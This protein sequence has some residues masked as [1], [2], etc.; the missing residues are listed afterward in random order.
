MPTS[1]SLARLRGP[2]VA[3]TLAGVL[4]VAG[5][6]AD[7]G[8]P[9]PEGSLTPASPSTSASPGASTSPSDAATASTPEPTETGAT[10]GPTETGAPADPSP[11]GVAVGGLVEGFPSDVVPVPPQAEV[12][13]SNA[14]EA[15]GGRTVA[16][17]GRTDASAEDVVAFY[18]EALTSQGFTATTPP[19]VDGASV[20]TFTRGQGATDLLTLSVTS[21]QAGQ[22]FSIGGRLG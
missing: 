15:D 14:V 1:T 10:D 19:G 2:L 5:C 17:A 18:T 13:L 6:T 7:E 3:A 8:L 16:L 20:T 4:G 11:T 22:D 9:T 12:T 21:S